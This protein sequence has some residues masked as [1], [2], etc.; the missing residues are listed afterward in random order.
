MSVDLAKPFQ[1][2]LNDLSDMR[3]NAKTIM[4]DTSQN[5]FNFPKTPGMVFIPTDTGNGYIQDQPYF[6]STDGTQT[7]PLGVRKHTHSADTDAQGGLFENVVRKNLGNLQWWN[8]TTYNEEDFYQLTSGTTGAVVDDDASGAT[9]WVRM[10]SGTVTNGWADIK[11]M[12]VLAD[13]GEDS[14]FQIRFNF[15]G[16]YTNYI[17]RLGINAESIN[18]A[19]DPTRDSYGIDFCSGQSNYQC[20]SC[21]GVSRSTTSSGKPVGNSNVH[22]WYIKHFA[23]DSYDFIFDV[24]FDNSVHKVTD[25]SGAGLTQSANLFQMG[26]KST[27]TTSKT[28]SFRGAVY[29]GRIG[30]SEWLWYA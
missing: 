19:N 5:I 4:V 26:V 17:G 10:I 6:I 12:G 29:A 13:F 15:D 11:K 27:N 21:D 24:D 14:A 23:G 25:V 18:D 3:L 20:F 9:G 30:A 16:P 8:Q 22:S 28:L 7:I 1:F 2:P